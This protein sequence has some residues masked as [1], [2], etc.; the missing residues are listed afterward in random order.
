M[1]R[2]K[3]KFVKN[4]FFGSHQTYDQESET[5]ISTIKKDNHSQLPLNNLDENEEE[6][7]LIEKTERINSSE[8]NDKKRSMKKSEFASP[9]YLSLIKMNEL[10]IIISRFFAKPG[11]G[12]IKNCFRYLLLKLR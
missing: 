5:A 11:Q 7:K 10:E 3:M 8:G 12:K 6:M 2:K 4:L 9:Y 1:K